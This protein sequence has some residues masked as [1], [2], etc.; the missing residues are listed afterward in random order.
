MN[1]ALRII[2][3]SGT[4]LL[5]T[6]NSV[7]ARSLAVRETTK[8]SNPDQVASSPRENSSPRNDVDKLP[9]IEL[10]E[11]ELKGTVVSGIFKPIAIIE[12]TASN[13]T[14]WYKEGDILS[15]AKIVEIERG[16]IILEIAGSR[17][18]CG[19]PSGPMAEDVAM[20]CRALEVDSAI[21]VGEKVGE[22]T[23]RLELDQAI[24]I[25]T[26]IGKIMKE[27]RIRP[28]FALGKAAGIQVDRIKDESVIRKM[29]LKDGD[30]VKGVN[31]FGLMTPTRLFEAYRKYKRE[32]QIEVQ[33]LREESPI[34]LTYNIAR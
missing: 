22:N 27:A 24:G 33:V 25:V 28:Y 23:W 7:I 30:V 8:Q 17:Y 9:T 14:Y 16:A 21:P 13:K 2:I 19:L 4:M 20:S 32:S 31:G 3:I 15:G 1:R 5:V 18:I 29:G 26:K 12:N 6:C 11:I 10:K 34:T